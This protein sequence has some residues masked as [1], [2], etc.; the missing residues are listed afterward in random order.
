MSDNGGNIKYHTRFPRSLNE[1]GW[2]RQGQWQ[3]EESPHWLVIIGAALIGAVAL[4]AFLVLVL[5]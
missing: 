4:W 3:G 1:A 5:G 2:S